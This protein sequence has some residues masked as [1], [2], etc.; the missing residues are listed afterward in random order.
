MHYLQCPELLG[1][2]VVT[3]GNGMFSTLYP[4]HSA[5]ACKNSPHH[6]CFPLSSLFPYFLNLMLQIKNPGH[7]FIKGVQRNL[8][9]IGIGAAI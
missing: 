9:E 4:V 5:A 7:F 1:V 2:V 3:R 8:G 6:N